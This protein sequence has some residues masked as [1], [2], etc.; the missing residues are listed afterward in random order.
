MWDFI[1]PSITASSIKAFTHTTYI[2]ELLYHLREASW[3]MFTVTLCGCVCVCVC[4]CREG[5]GGSVGAEVC[6]CVNCVC[7]SVW[8]CINCKK[9]TRKLLICEVNL[10]KIDFQKLL[11]CKR[12]HISLLIRWQIWIGSSISISN[13]W[14]QIIWNLYLFAV[15]GWRGRKHTEWFIINNSDN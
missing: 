15:W 6:A 12:N 5:E 1:L 14:N 11:V 4:E 7:L 8:V 10:I 9:S 13:N 3:E 2:Y